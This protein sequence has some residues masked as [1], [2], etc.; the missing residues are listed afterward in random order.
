MASPPVPKPV[1]TVLSK[2]GTKTLASAA[3]PALTT[4]DVVNAW[5][6]YA[7]TCQIE[8]TKREEIRADRDVRIASIKE[9]GQVWRAFIENTFAERRDIFSKSFDM[10]ESGLD[11]GDDKKISAALAMITEQIKVSPMKQA[12]EMMQA[13]SD[14]DVKHI[15]V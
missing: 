5:K 1:L 6:E 11:S 8:E 3:Q 12:A 2:T 14:P 7:T 15:E 10:L 4:L 9:Q 13:M